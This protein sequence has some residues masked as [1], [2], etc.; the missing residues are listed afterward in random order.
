MIQD[1]SLIKDF[2]IIVKIDKQV[3]IRRAVEADL[4]K[5]HDIEV[6]SFSHPYGKDFF[7][8]L[9]KQKTT[10]FFVAVSDGEVIGYIIGLRRDERV[11]H[12]V[13]IAVTPGQ[14]G[15]G[16]GKSL[17]NRVVEDLGSEEIWLEVSTENEKARNFYE[18]MGFRFKEHLPRYYQSGEDAIRMVLFIA[19]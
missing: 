2:V 6:K 1:R 8:Y 4:S 3:Q 17:L 5:M 14:Q 12:V 16:I 13:S 15:K 9:W 10:R 18:T 11:G 19:K 7:R